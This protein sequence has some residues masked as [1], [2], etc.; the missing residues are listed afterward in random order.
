MCVWGGGGRMA[1]LSFEERSLNVN[2]FLGAIDDDLTEVN[3]N[4]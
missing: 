2:V 4:N 3:H 1:V